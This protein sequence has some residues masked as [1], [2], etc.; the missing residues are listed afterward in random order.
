MPSRS[1]AR[2]GSIRLG[3]AAAVLAFGPAAPAAAQDPAA[4][5]PKVLVV[6]DNDFAGPGGT[7]MQ[8]L[9]PLISDPQVG[10]LGFT[11]V[12]GDGWENEEAARLLR[13]LEIA[14]RSDI[15]VVNGATYP[16]MRTVPEMK[17]WEQRFGRIPWKGAWGGLGPIDKVPVQQPALPHL[18]EGLPTT[19]PASGLAASF[20]IKQVHAH[21]HQVTVI[22]AGPLTDIA[23]AIRMDPSF[24]AD[25]KQLVFMGGLLD[26]SM[27]SVTGDADFASDF[28]L[29]FDPEAA[30]IALTAPWPKI[31]A[32]GNVSNSVMMDRALMDRVA[33]VKTP[34]TAY[35]SKYFNPLP[36]WDE[37][38]AAIAVDPSL[39]TKSVDAFM[40]VDVSGGT[41]YGRAHIWPEALAPKD[42]GV[43]AVT[44]VQ[45]IDRTRFT[46]GFV[47]A[48]QWTPPPK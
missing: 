17:S 14:G 27:Q 35:L 38:A 9:L 46:D 29:I 33:A 6:M 7:D 10:V 2:L 8:A 32:V 28:N 4:E 30:H 12:T 34:L 16:L 19:P 45:D 26:T 37:M 43:R 47:K 15:P 44:I 24:A 25:A 39:V 3:L 22:A 11:V 13:F 20:L 23:L 21:P 31:T 5:P 48:A 18:D 42:M 36:L 41:D 40:D 1:P